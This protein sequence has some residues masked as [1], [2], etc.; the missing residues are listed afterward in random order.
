[1]LAFAKRPAG[2]ETSL[3]GTC[4]AVPRMAVAWP[5]AAVSA[6]ITP[7]GLSGIASASETA[8]TRSKDE[9]YMFCS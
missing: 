4:I 9:T 6:A 8:V 3:I 1:M 7:Q 5:V 2:F